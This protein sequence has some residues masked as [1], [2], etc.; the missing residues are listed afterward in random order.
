MQIKCRKQWRQLP[1]HMR[2]FMVR[3]LHWMHVFGHFVW[4]QI[5]QR[6]RCS[7]VVFGHEKLPLP[8][9]WM[10]KCKRFYIHFFCSVPFK[11]DQNKQSTFVFFFF[12]SCKQST[13]VTASYKIDGLSMQSPNE[14]FNFQ[15]WPFHH[16]CTLTNIYDNQNIG[17]VI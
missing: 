1:W 17:N 4:L 8:F 3:E 12:S 6:L 7:H 9:C 10:A 11:T 15:F 16:S 14:C 13:T 2:A 5:H